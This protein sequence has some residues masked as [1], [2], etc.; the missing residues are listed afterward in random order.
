MLLIDPGDLADGV[1]VP[2]HEMSVEPITDPQRQLQVHPCPGQDLA[3][4]AAGGRSLPRPPPRTCR[5]SRRRATADR[6]V[7]FTLTD[8]PTDRL[9]VV[10][11]ASMTRRAPASTTVPT[12][13]IR[14]L[15][16]MRTPYSR[17]TNNIPSDCHRWFRNH[18]GSFR[19]RRN[20]RTITAQHGVAP[21]TSSYTRCS[22]AGVTHPRRAPTRRHV[23]TD[24][25]LPGTRIMP[26]RR[27]PNFADLA[28]PAD[29]I[30]GS[31][32]GYQSLHRWRSRYG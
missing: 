18:T 7:P 15:Y 24:T 28:C 11:G 1:G 13:L 16:M 12:S 3:Q 23:N 5:Q 26:L 20:L 27:C 21:S 31:A 32:R 22:P 25:A 29:Q 14:P 19:Q 4:G 30:G 6:Q 17:R 10:F 8:P 9:A 2:L